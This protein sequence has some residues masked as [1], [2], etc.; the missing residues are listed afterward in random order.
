[1]GLFQPVKRGPQFAGIN[2]VRGAGTG[3]GDIPLP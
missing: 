3:S 1:M 2:L